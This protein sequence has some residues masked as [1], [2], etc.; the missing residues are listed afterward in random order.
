LTR[1]IGNAEDRNANNYSHATISDRVFSFDNLPTDKLHILSLLL[2]NVICL[3]YIA[4]HKQLVDVRLIN[5][6][7]KT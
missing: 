7:F 2:N 4:G 1:I 5:N 3:Y 6:C